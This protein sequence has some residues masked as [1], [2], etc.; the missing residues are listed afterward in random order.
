V[1]VQSEEKIAY[2]DEGRERKRD[3]RIWKRYKSGE[4]K[5]RKIL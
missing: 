1:V 3:R 4:G 2:V 5:R